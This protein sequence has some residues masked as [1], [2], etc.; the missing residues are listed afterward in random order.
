MKIKKSILQF[1]GTI[2]LLLLIQFVLYAC[3]KCNQDFYN[4]LLG[5]RGNTLGGQE[6]L[7]AI[8]NQST[9]E[10]PANFVLP[11][12]FN[13][14]TDIKQSNIQDSSDVIN[15]VNTE[16]NLPDTPTS[17]ITDIIIFVQLIFF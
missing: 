14:E 11:A 6:L 8:R 3:P 10:Q 7:E 5:Q 1:S 4:E 12:T 2:I 15:T 16:N 9:S 17:Y 13:S